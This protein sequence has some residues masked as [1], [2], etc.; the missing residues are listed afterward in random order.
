[1]ISKCKDP[2]SG[3]TDTGNRVI[4]TGAK[5][6]KIITRHE[7]LNPDALM[8]QG[9]LSHLALGSEPPITTGQ[10]KPQSTQVS[11]NTEVQA[12]STLHLWWSE[13]AQ[14]LAKSEPSLIFVSTSPRQMHKRG[15][16]LLLR[17]GY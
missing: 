15:L 12:A 3:P 17:P 5:A 16:F 13:C 2:H 8:Q 1:M 11:E 9:V 10:K 6:C 14:Y 7:I 4:F